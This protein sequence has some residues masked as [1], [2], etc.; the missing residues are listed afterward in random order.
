MSVAV[1][2]TEAAELEGIRPASKDVMALIRRLATLTNRAKP[3]KVEQDAI[4]TLI[5]EEMAATG[6]KK[7]THKGV[8]VVEIVTV[9][10]RD[11][12]LAGILKEF[13]GAA[14]YVTPKVTKRFDVK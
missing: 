2:E 7:L 8:V 4:K 6:T 9:N 3:I 12:N 11:V 14:K 1:T 10:G 13:P 5:R